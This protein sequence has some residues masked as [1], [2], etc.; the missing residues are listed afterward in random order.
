[1]D[2]KFS[3][4]ILALLAMVISAC[5]N[6]NDSP[7]NG[8]DTLPPIQSFVW[9]EAESSPK[10]LEGLN[11]FVYDSE[12]RV[13]L[14]ETLVQKT[15]YTYDGLKC[16][17]VM[18]S[19]PSGEK[20]Q[21]QYIVFNK[22]GRPVSE[23]STDWENN[24]SADMKYEYDSEGRI[25]SYDFNVSDGRYRRSEFKYD[26]STGLISEAIVDY[27]PIK[28]ST[29]RFKIKYRFCYSDKPNPVAFYPECHQIFDAEP[30]LAFTGL[31]GYQRNRLI[32]KIYVN[33]IDVDADLEVFAYSYEFSAEGK[34]T[35]IIET[36][37][38]L[39]AEGEV[40]SSAAPIKIT[41]IKY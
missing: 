35:A 28:G 8:K 41:D 12:G 27:P 36:V 19:I 30:A 25:I 1:M 26:S 11:R 38:L 6:D 29:R 31:D 24:A 33:S 5:D 4:V 14:Y 3:F 22:D 15:T 7:S 37:S 32:D 20:L 13:T 16:T 34:L 21:D 2:K 40:M 39:D 9:P 17:G 23:E 18:T 10:Q